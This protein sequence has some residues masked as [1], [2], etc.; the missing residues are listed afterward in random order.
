MKEKIL[1]KILDHF[2]DAS[3][4]VRDMSHLHA[5]HLQS[6]SQET[7]FKL[8]ISTPS[9]RQMSIL[10]AHKMIYKILEQE[11]LQIHALEIDIQR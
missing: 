9:L 1:Q 6:D 10:Q 2:H 4:E 7:H 11:M 3:V 8:I 5:G